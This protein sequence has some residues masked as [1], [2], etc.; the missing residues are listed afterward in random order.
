M[1]ASCLQRWC[2][3]GALAAVHCWQASGLVF[4]QYLA[5][6][7]LSVTSLAL[8]PMD[9]HFIAAADG[10]CQA[11]VQGQVQRQGEWSV[12][13]KCWWRPPQMA[14]GSM[15]C[16][17]SSIPLVCSSRHA[18]QA[19]FD[20]EF[21]TPSGT[22]KLL[23]KL[24]QRDYLWPLGMFVCITGLP[25]HAADSLAS[26]AVVTGWKPHLETST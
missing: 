1:H 6:N 20:K 17:E 22:C 23:S 9:S 2:R 4:T 26:W 14:T 19:R 8:R 18:D 16:S 21:G 5:G 11:V 12:A 24:L 7:T 10:S 15:P 3:H 25:K 13:G